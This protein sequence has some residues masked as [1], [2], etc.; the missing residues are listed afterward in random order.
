MF[1]LLAVKDSKCTANPPAYPSHLVP[2]TRKAVSETARQSA[3]TQVH[4]R[5]L[6]GQRIG[7]VGHGAPAIYP[8]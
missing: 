2:E 8:K 1:C 7:E 5:R 4:P 6:A 3:A